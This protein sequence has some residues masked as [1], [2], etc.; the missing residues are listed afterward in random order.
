MGIETNYSNN[1]AKP[2]TQKK[3]RGPAHKKRPPYVKL[4]V[5]AVAVAAVVTIV[6]PYALQPM[7]STRPP[8]T[9]EQA[10]NTQQ[11]TKAD[12]SAQAGNA[13]ATSDEEGSGQTDDTSKTASPTYASTDNAN[14]IAPSSEASSQTES[15]DAAPQPQWHEGWTETVTVPAEYDYSEPYQVYVC[16]VCG[17]ETPNFDE[18]I[19]H[20]QQHAGSLEAGDEG[21]VSVTRGGYEV[22]VTPEHQEEIHHPGYW[23]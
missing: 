14:E 12:A 7:A 15:R 3:K 22:L 6:M 13:S 11:A 9:N 2:A 23:S 16:A 21:F 17:Y 20:M 10:A 19:G 8:A 1:A 4:A 5:A 18:I